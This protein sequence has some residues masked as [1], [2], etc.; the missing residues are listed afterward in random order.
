MNTIAAHSTKVK[1]YVFYYGV[2]CVSYYNIAYY[3]YLRILLIFMYGAVH[4]L[5]LYIFYDIYIYIYI[6]IYI[7]FQ[8]RVSHTALVRS[9][10]WSRDDLRLA[11]AGIDGAVYEWSLQVVK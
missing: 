7:I 11:T 3:I 8:V 10:A 2:I 4:T 1:L 9:I 6:Y 5:R